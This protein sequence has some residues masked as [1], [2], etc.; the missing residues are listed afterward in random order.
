MKNIEIFQH[1]GLGGV[2]EL[3]H[4]NKH[5]KNMSKTQDII[6]KT[7]QKEASLGNIFEIFLQILFKSTF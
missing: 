5:F 2:G 6:S 1:R 4:F 7:Q 3:G